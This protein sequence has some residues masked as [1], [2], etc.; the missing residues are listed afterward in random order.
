M[1]L[2]GGDK[3]SERYMRLRKS[4]KDALRS[5]YTN[6]PFLRCRESTLATTL[7]HNHSGPTG[8]A[9]DC[10]CGLQCPR[11]EADG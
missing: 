4:F 3:Q 10:C 1:F 7:G 11:G 8:C 2:G 5:K 6:G 9:A